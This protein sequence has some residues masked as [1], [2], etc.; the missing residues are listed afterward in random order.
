MSSILTA[1]MWL[2]YQIRVDLEFVRWANALLLHREL[3]DGLWIDESGTFLLGEF[4]SLM[5]FLLDF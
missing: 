2:L 1:I 5:A 3:N 4:Q